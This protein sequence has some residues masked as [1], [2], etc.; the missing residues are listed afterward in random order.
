MTKGDGVEND[1][2][3]VESRFALPAFRYGGHSHTV[4]T[5]GVGHGESATGR[6]TRPLRGIALNQL[7]RGWPP[8]IPL[9]AGTEPRPYVLIKIQVTAYVS[10][11]AVSGMTEL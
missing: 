5:F 2:R 4:A 8:D 6:E 9:R 7:R 10:P 1:R 11:P 3:G